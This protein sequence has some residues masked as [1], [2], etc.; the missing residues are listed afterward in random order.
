MQGEGEGRLSVVPRP[1]HHGISQ[2]LPPTGR[3]GRASWSA[4]VAPGPCSE[5]QEL[6]FLVFRMVGKG[7]SVPAGP[8]FLE[9]GLCPGS[10]PGFTHVPPQGS[11]LPSGGEDAGGSAFPMCPPALSLG[12]SSS[13][14]E[15]SGL[16]W[17]LVVKIPPSSPGG[18][19]RVRSWSGS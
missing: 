19:V 17:W 6:L 14:E 8:T 12:H 13:Q 16:P 11:R 5:A 2:C 18:A 7:S 3:E 9:A 1:R 15:G 10:W 4:Q